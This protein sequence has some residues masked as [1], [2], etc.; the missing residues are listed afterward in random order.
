MSEI[1]GS[2]S[3]TQT[4]PR[5]E[6]RRQARAEMKKLQAADPRDVLEDEGFTALAHQCGLVGLAKMMEEDV[7][8]ACGVRGK[9]EQNPQKRTGSRN[10][11]ELGAVWI[12]GAWVQVERPRAVRV[13]G[14]E[15]ELDSYRKAQNPEFLSRAVLTSTILGVSLRNHAKVVGAINPLPSEMKTSGLS[16]S[17]L[18]RRFIAAADSFL[19]TFLSR[20]LNER[21]LAVWLDAVAEGDYSVLAAIGLTADGTKKVLGLRQGATETADFCAEFLED[22]KSRGLSAKQGILWVVDGGAGTLKALREVF[23][24]DVLIQRCR[25]HKRR[26]IVEKLTLPASEKE[27]VANELEAVWAIQEPVLAGAKLEL[28]ARGLEANEHCAAARSLREGLKEMLTC[29]RLG[30]PPG[31]IPSLT[32]TNVIESTFSVHEGVAHRVKRW[33]NGAQVQRWVAASSARA[34][35]AF[36]RVGDPEL[37]ARLARA[38]ERHVS[39]CNAEPPRPALA[40]AS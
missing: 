36:E 2:N 30:V 28:L 37:M 34:E 13:G 23:G 40:L 29:T 7:N 14:G 22:L 25:V 17:A 5:A 16:K 32:N 24:Q 39:K 19:S 38:L 6:R 35:K 11:W 1:N 4:L 12:G 27:R 33:Q 26:N 15:I 31:L 8:N 10:G 20:A 18:G 3:S 9:W 21:Y